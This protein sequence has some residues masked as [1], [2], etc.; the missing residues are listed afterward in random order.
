M[1]PF[2]D[3]RPYTDSEVD[4]VLQSLISN[5][6]VLK[7]LMGLQYPGFMSKLPFVKFY[8]KQKLIANVRTIHT[9]NDYQKIFKNYWLEKETPLKIYQPI[10]SRNNF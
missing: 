3:I 5:S 6:E 4:G 8:A 10:F 9:I 1:D 7:A 2:K